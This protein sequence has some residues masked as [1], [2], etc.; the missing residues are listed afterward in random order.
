MAYFALN[1]APRLSLYPLGWKPCISIPKVLQFNHCFLAL[2]PVA[3]SKLDIYR[4]GRDPRPVPYFFA[5]DRGDKKESVSIAQRLVGRD[6][7]VAVIGGSTSAPSVAAAPVISQSKTPMIA[8]YSNAFQVVKGNDYVWRWCSVAD[9]QGYI[10]VHYTRTEL[11]KEK[12]AVLAQDDEYG[13]GIAR[14]VKEGVKKWGGTI[15]FEKYYPTGE[16]EFRANLTEIKRLGADVVFSMGFGPSQASVARQGAELGLFPSAQ[17]ICS[18]TAD[19]LNWFNTVGREGDGTLGILEFATGEQ[20]PEMEKFLKGWEQEYKTRIVSHEA[21][22]TYDAT[23]M[24]ID[25]IRRGGSTKEGIKNALSQMKSFKGIIGPPHTYTELREPAY[26]L[27]IG[28][29]NASEK[30]YKVLKY[31]TTPDIIDPVRWAAFY[32]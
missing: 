9:V 18:C 16:K 21:G 8:A 19:D 4:V 13:R 17:L 3:R 27:M 2:W 32:K 24:L 10:M 6:N 11:K 14:G 31:Y 12:M 30:E 23:R 5:D 1:V 7:V 26:P 25:A 29:Y 15:V 20:T 28:K 22:T